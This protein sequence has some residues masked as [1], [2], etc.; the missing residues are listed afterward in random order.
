MIY[1]QVVDCVEYGTETKKMSRNYPSELNMIYDFT[2]QLNAVSSYFGG[3][4]P[5]LWDS[6]LKELKVLLTHLSNRSLIISTIPPQQ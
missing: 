6:T 3:N 1:Y 5:I 2:K 4:S